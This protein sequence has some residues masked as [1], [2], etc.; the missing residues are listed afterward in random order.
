MDDSSPYL[1]LATAYLPPVEYLYYLNK[2][3]NIFIDI[4]ENYIK[5]T[6]RN[7]CYVMTANGRLCL[8]V[9]VIKTFGNHT[10]IKDIKIDYSQPWQRSHWRAI[11]SAYNSSPFFIYYRDEIEPIFRKKFLFLIDLNTELLNA[12][13]KL[14]YINC[15]IKFTKNYIEHSEKLKDLKYSI[16]PKS[17][18]ISFSN[19]PEYNQVFSE[20]YGFIS[21]L[22]SIDLL[23]N[24]GKFSKEYLDRIEV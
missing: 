2:T 13:N 10:Q 23:F 21:N 6:Y 12:L 7:R 22:S 14:Y 18:H 5:Q 9:P 16:T 17:K 15:D 24:S 1:I 11:E 4:Y 20:K 3:G 19:F 8:T